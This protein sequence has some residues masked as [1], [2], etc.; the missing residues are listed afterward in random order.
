MNTSLCL[1]IAAFIA[2]TEENFN[3][4]PVGAISKIKTQNFHH[5]D[6]KFMQNA[7]ILKNTTTLLH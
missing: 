3:V 7:Q 6:D 2:G 1:R 5:H 4:M